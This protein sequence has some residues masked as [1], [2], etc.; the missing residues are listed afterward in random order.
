MRLRRT[1]LVAACG[2][3]ARQALGGGSAAT[4]V[5]ATAGRSLL[6][7]GALAYGR[8]DVSRV[9]QGFLGAQPE[10]LGGDA[11]A[12]TRLWAHEARRA[13]GDRLPDHDVGL[14][15]AK[16]EDLLVQSA[17][18]ASGSTPLGGDAWENV[19]PPDEDLDFCDLP[20]VRLLGDRKDEDGNTVATDGAQTFQPGG[21]RDAGVFDGEL[22]AAPE[23][24]DDGVDDLDLEKMKGE[25]DD[26]GNDEDEGGGKVA[27][28]QVRSRR[29]QMMDDATHEVSHS[30][31]VADYHDDMSMSR[32]SGTKSTVGP[33][34]TPSPERV[35]YARLE[36]GD[37]ARRHLVREARA[38]E[39][40]FAITQS[41]V[42]PAL[43][44]VGVVDVLRVARAL[45][46]H[47][48]HV[49]LLGP[50]ASGGTR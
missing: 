24:L 30:V 28:G 39:A 41:M 8:V 35:A 5:T 32:K 9:L 29:S 10:D 11:A 31:D 1:R 48:G 27:E 20:T 3:A 18:G 47:C 34:I 40:A 42:P 21:D 16:F 17:A 25:E 15:K 33:V 26:D 13:L 7:T 43:F 22:G 45:R 23:K 36:G 4:P 37:R 44:E 50:G 6:V 2:T 19:V 38:V 46:R 14:D 12:L 49:V